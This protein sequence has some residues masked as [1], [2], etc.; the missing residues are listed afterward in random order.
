MSYS[1]VPYKNEEML[2]VYLGQLADVRAARMLINCRLSL[3]TDVCVRA[4]ACVRACV[5]V[6]VCKGA[7]VLWHFFSCCYIHTSQCKHS[8]IFHSVDL[9]I[10]SF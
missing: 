7:F 8:F 3:L 10:I 5:W 2:K 4:H 6:C 9:D 1:V